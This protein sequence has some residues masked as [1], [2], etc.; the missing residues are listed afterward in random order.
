MT[1][2]LG[3]D[4]GTTFVAA[5]VARPTGVAM[6]PLGEQTVVASAAV[7]VRPDGSIVTGDA[8]ERRAVSQ[9]ALVARGVK[10]RLGDPEPI[11][12][13]D[14]SYPVATLLGAQL[15]DVVQKAADREGEPAERVVL[16]YPVTWTPARRGWFDE[17]ARA[18]DLAASRLVTT[19]E[20]AAHHAT[21]GRLAGGIV[22]VYDL[23]GGFEAT[24]V[25][26][27]P[28]GPEILGTPEG[29]EG[30]GGAD[31]DEAIL[32][33][34]NDAMSGELARLDMDDA[35]TAVATGPAA[36][37]LRS[38]EGDPV[39]GHGGCGPGFPARPPRRDPAGPDDLRADA[40]GPSRVDGR[41]P[42]A[43]G[44]VGRIDPCGRRR[45]AARR[46]LVANPARR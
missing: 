24:V 10:R 33:Y 12:L 11:R 7:A 22:A 31:V 43:H 14:R 4:L 25:R 1:Y 17:V 2:T 34:V 35:R 20:A 39:A 29:V 46:R 30:L 26:T 40:A 36:S 37:G 19:A 28:D 3:V 16:T 42:I 9:P 6:V 21:P 18:A 38:G 44:A 23:G 41:G 15:R 13:G 45:G 8:A 27:R 32:S 5:A